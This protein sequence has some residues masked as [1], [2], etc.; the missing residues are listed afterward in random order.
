MAVEPTNSKC[1]CCIDR[2]T[3]VIVIAVLHILVALGVLYP[4][5]AMGAEG[6]TMLWGPIIILTVGLMT[7]ATLLYGAIKYNTTAINI[8]IVL[9]VIEII[10]G[11]AVA[12]FLTLFAFAFGANLHWRLTS[13]CSLLL[14]LL[15]SLSIFLLASTSFTKKSN[16]ENMIPV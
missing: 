2:R 11:L 5:G 7:G 4:I 3:G 9:A 13:F 15:S 10:N 1:C 14:L 6:Q 8:H 16:Q 12:G